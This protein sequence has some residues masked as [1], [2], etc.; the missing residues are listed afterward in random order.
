MT[1]YPRFAVFTSGVMTAGILAA[2]IRTAE[3]LCMRV[4]REWSPTLARVGVARTSGCAIFG[5]HGA[6][7]APQVDL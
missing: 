5:V 2:R 3:P 7:T 4:W 1:A 6:C